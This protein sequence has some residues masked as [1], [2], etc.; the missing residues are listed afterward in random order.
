L[1][2]GKDRCVRFW[3]FDKDYLSHTVCG[4]EK[5]GVEDKYEVTGNHYTCMEVKKNA[6]AN[7]SLNTKPIHSMAITDMVI[8]GREQEELIVTSCADGVIRFWK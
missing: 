7:H 8:T 4:V 6:L 5:R 1:T 2:A 3:S